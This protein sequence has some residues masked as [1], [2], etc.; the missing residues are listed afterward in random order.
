MENDNSIIQALFQFH[1][2]SSKFED[3]AYK[4]I[5]EGDSLVVLKELDL[6]KAAVAEATTA[7]FA[8]AAATRRA[9]HCA[10]EAARDVVY[11]ETYS[12]AK[13][14]FTKTRKINGFEVLNLRSMDKVWVSHYDMEILLKTA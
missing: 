9:P 7:A 4:K 13:E 14:E 3:L 11:W 5:K 2:I 10:A 8:G 1:P 6:T 12:Q